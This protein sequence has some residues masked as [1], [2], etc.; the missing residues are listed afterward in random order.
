MNFHGE[1]RSNATHQSATDPDSRLLRKSLNPHE[2]TLQYVGGLLMENRHGL[3]V[4]ASAVIGSG[5]AEREVAIGQVAA[6]PYGPQEASAPT[7]ALINGR[8]STAESPTRAARPTSPPRRKDS[9]VV[10][11]RRGIRGYAVSEAQVRKRNRRSLRL[12][13]DRRA[14]CASFAIVGS[15]G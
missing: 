3:V 7:R 6:L 1:R 12:D 15:R 8:S 4:H 10:A 9:A 11:A 2:P 14:P 13:E 5:T